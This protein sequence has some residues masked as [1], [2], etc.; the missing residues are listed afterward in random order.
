MLT[1]THAFCHLYPPMLAS[2]MFL[3]HSWSFSAQL[4]AVHVKQSSTRHA[5]SYW[6]IVSLGCRLQC[7]YVQ[8]RMWEGYFLLLLTKPHGH[9]GLAA[10]ALCLQ[11]GIPNKFVPAYVEKKLLQTR[12]KIVPCIIINNNTLLCYS[13]LIFQCTFQTLIN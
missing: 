2:A 13:T 3:E 9:L 5:T 12:K 11:K 8:A 4:L 1:K 10:L 6:E 7:I